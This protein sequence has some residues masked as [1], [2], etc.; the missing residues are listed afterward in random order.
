MQLFVKESSTKNINWPFTY[1]PTFPKNKNF[2][3]P[4]KWNFYSLFRLVYC[5]LGY[6]PF[7]Y[8]PNFPKKNFQQS[9]S[10]SCISRIFFTL[11]IFFSILKILQPFQACLLH[12]GVM[13]P[14][15]SHT[16][17]LLSKGGVTIWTLKRF[18]T[19][20]DTNVIFHEISSP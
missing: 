1:F 18:F 20:V 8:F 16:T 19:S 12:T 9:N 11:N 6:W 10:L 2:Q 14:D 4:S 15:M 5:T 3:L 7:T 17:T 13:M